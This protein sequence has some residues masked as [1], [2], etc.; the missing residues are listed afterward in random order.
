MASGT[1]HYNLTKPASTEMYD[2]AVWNENMDN[3]DTQMYQNE[4]RD[5]LP[6]IDF[7]QL[8]AQQ[9]ADLKTALGIS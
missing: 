4:A 1:A 3:I 5:V 7:S 2:L 8:S 6:D 9:I